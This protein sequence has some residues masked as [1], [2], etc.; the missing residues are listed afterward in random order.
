[1]WVRAHVCT[2]G[3]DRMKIPLLLLHWQV[4]PGQPGGGRAVTEGT[5]HAPALEDLPQCSLGSHSKAGAAGSEVP[6][7]GQHQRV[8]KQPGRD[9][10]PGPA[11]HKGGCTSPWKK[12][13]LSTL[14]GQGLGPKMRH[15][16][17]VTSV[18]SKPHRLQARPK[19]KAGRI[20]C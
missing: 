20:E 4:D 11:K 9:P 7:A 6:A 19:C 3:K 13:K 1:M 10:A 2:R 16:T 18:M 14:G 17:V 5:E 8:C 12:P 15:T